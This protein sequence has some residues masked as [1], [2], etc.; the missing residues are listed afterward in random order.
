MSSTLDVAIIGAGP[1]GLSVGSHLRARGIEVRVFGYPMETWREAMPP[2]MKLKSEGFASSLSDP[3][4]DLTL[5][6]YC[7]AKNEPFART[8]L[9]V[10]SETF[11]AYGEAFQHLIE[12]RRPPS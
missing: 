9:P 1:Y 8:G 3:S 7:S 10:K 2:G 11:V 4:G 6:N 5:E 12:T